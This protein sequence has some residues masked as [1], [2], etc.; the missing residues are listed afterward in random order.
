MREFYIFTAVPQ[1]RTHPGTG[2]GEAD[3]GCGLRFSIA[4]HGGVAVVLAA[5]PPE[6]DES[7]LGIRLERNHD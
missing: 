5:R 2:R 7:N 1:P 6:K 4:P 3:M